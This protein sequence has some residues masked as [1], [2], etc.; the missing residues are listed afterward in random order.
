MRVS[1]Q[2]KQLAILQVSVVRKM[3]GAIHRIEYF[4]TVVKTLE[5]DKGIL[6]GILMPYPFSLPP[7][8]AGYAF[9]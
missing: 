2:D 8:M 1:T 5:N 6:Q 4:S 3:D 9:G 7:G